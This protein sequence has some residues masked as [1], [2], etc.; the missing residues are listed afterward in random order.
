[1]SSG[2]SG[3]VLAAGSSSR[4]RADSREQGR[5]GDIKQ[6]IEL[7][8][9]PLVRWVVDAALG[10]RLSQLIVVLGHAS[11]RV[12]RTLDGLEVLMI[13]NPNYRLGQSTSVITGLA[14]VAPEARAVM[15]LPADQPLVSS[16]L[17]DRLIA[18]YL[19]GGKIVVPVHRG[20]RG[21]P[22][23][24][25]RVFFPELER[26]EGDAGGRKLLPRHAARIVEVEVEDPAELADVDTPEDLRRMVNLLRNAER[27]RTPRG[28]RAAPEPPTRSERDAGC[29][30]ES[31]PRP[32]GAGCR[33]RPAN[34]GPCQ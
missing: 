24:F 19:A 28:H 3:I 14:Q 8:G 32:A 2:V 13:D 1:M 5:L 6:L 30:R 9:R 33:A 22:V 12:A 11:E 31:T 21:A 23:L 18:A 20:R 27:G 10:S 26:L 34:G 16:R 25:D 29:D 4:F 7:D 15:F 17:V